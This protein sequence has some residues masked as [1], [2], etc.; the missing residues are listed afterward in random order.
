[1]KFKL[2]AA[3]LATAL[4]AFSGA[5]LAS[6]DH[7]KPMR[8]GIVSPGKAADFELVAKADMLQ[9][10]VSD[11]GKPRDV[12]KA[13]AMVTLLS[14]Q[15][16]QEVELKPVGDRLEAA[17]AFQVA[18]GTKVVAVVTDNGKA[19]GTARFTLK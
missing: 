15:N 13:S 14:G 9:I 11:H 18:T 2:V 16:K 19:L 5:A 10:Y 1:M 7:H 8:G 4:A 3:T 12:S 6:D 17:G